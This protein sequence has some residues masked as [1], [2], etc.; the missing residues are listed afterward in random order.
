MP[1]IFLDAGGSAPTT[2]RVFRGG[3]VITRPLLDYNA[4]EVVTEIV[5]A[6]PPQYGI[7]LAQR[8][9]ELGRLIPNGVDSYVGL[10]SGLP[11][12]SGTGGTEATG[13]GYAR[14]A[15][16]RWA[17]DV[18]GSI[19]RRINVGVITFPDLTAQLS[20]RGWGIWDAASGGNLLAFGLLRTGGG[21]PIVH[22]MS[23]TD[24]PRFSHGELRVG[25]Q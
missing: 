18:T 11:S 15:H 2:F 5:S 25:I 24:T 21:A 4:P 14:V 23:A 12:T 17:F 7:P 13:S 1:E 9:V 19:I 22:T 6:R 16:S 20:V 8:Q 3:S 10:F